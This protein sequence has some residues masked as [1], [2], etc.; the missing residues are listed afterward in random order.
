MRHQN[1]L[2]GKSSCCPYQR[3]IYIG[4]AFVKPHHLDP[5]LLKFL[6]PLFDRLGDN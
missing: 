6:T 2:D 5:V 3:G 4:D 1:C